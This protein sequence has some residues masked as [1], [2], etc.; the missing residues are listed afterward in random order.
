MAVIFLSVMFLE[1]HIILIIPWADVAAIGSKTLPNL[2][3]ELK[4]YPGYHSFK[5]WKYVPERKQFECYAEFMACFAGKYRNYFAENKIMY[6][7][8]TVGCDNMCKK[9]RGG[10]KEISDPITASIYTFLILA[11]DNP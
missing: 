9:F 8:C 6:R 7:P 1:I 11:K 4:D 5:E 2:E 3:K 10:E